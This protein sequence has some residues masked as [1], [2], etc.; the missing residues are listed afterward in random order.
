MWGPREQL[1]PSQGEGP[2]A[3][4]L[5]TPLPMTATFQ[6]TPSPPSVTDGTGRSMVSGLSPL[7]R[8]MQGKKRIH[9]PPLARAG[10]RA[11]LDVFKNPCCP[12]PFLLAGPPP[13]HHLPFLSPFFSAVA[14]ITILPPSGLPS[15]FRSS[16]RI[17]PLPPTVRRPTASGGVAAAPL[18]L[19][20][21]TIW[22]HPTRFDL[23]APF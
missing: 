19:R 3:S 20:P 7:R 11:H 16:S 18:R 8:L 10:S 5:R 12:Q 14:H 2:L 17:P 21:V 15:L 6:P 22:G 13:P 1:P 4:S 9:G 23:P